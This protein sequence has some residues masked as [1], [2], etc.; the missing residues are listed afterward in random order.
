MLSTYRT[1]LVQVGL[2]YVG[3]SV[4]ILAASIFWRAF[5]TGA[6]AVALALILQ[7]I[8]EP[9]LLFWTVPWEALE[10]VRT[11][12][13]RVNHFWLHRTQKL[14]RESAGCFAR[15]DGFATREGFVLVGANLD[16]SQIQSASQSAWRNMCE[17]SSTKEGAVGCKTMQ[18]LLALWLIVGGLI[19]LS[20]WRGVDLASGVLLS[21][22]C[23]AGGRFLAR[24]AERLLGPWADYVVSS[25]D[26]T[27]AKPLDG[28]GFA[29]PTFLWFKKGRVF[30]VRRVAEN[31]TPSGTPT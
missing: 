17:R 8:A 26:K 21:A 5:W 14:L 23:G 12:K 20:L 6:A 10:F 18:F 15:V 27:W 11:R 25:K 22:L 7:E 13:V 9:S 3:G 29:I 2:P 16:Q 1:N 19:V 31:E 28:D 24:P 30:E 4:L